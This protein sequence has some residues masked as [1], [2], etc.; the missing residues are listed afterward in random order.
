MGRFKFI[1]RMIIKGKIEVPENRS[2]FHVKGI[3]GMDY[4]D[5]PFNYHTIEEIC[6]DLKKYENI[7]QI[8]TL[9][10]PISKQTK[11]FIEA[12]REL[13]LT[14]FLIESFLDYGDS[15]PIDDLITVIIDH[16]KIFKESLSGPVD[17]KDG[18]LFKDAYG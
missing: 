12:T 4:T 6:D 18:G 15:Y 16:E 17:K 11:E 2:H 7:N 8:D 14:N 9:T 3:G 13:K 1:C 10:D 5:I